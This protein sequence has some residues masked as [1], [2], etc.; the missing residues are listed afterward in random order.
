VLVRSRAD[1]ARQVGEA[2]GADDPES[3]RGFS[4]TFLACLVHDI[5]LIHGALDRMDVVAEPIA[6]GAWAGGDAAAGTL[7]VDGGAQWRTTWMLL[8]GLMDF[9]ER[10]RLFFDDAI[11]ELT[12]PV[13]YHVD[14]PI[15]HAITTGAGGVHRRT[16]DLTVHD[17]FVAELEHFHAC[18]T[19]G[20]TTLTPPEQSVADLR[21]LRDLYLCR[22]RPR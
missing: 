16:V 2:V 19:A 5:N 1:E 12:F 18:V 4:Y 9:E 21:V 10:A 6:S 22:D 13:P 8:R 3:V 17:P 20:A 15:A 14:V 7:R 11:H